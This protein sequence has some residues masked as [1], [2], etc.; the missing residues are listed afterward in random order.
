P[1]ERHGDE[2]GFVI[3][4]PELG[5]ELV[6]EDLGA[7]ASEG[8][9]GPADGDSHE[10]LG[11]NVLR[12]SLTFAPGSRSRAGRTGARSAAERSRP[13]P[14]PPGSPDAQQARSRIASPRSESPSAWP[15]GR[16]S[17]A[18]AAARASGLRSSS[19][20]RAGRAD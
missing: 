6:R 18:R 20:A 12:G 19:A 3:A 13:G 8:H 1:L 9:L 16:A 17:R 14:D 2:I 11:G 5:D 7:P 15:A 10:R 4:F